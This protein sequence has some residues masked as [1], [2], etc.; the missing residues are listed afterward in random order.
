MSAHCEEEHKVE[1]EVP[2]VEETAEASEEAEEE[3]EQKPEIKVETAPQD[4]RFPSC[5]QSR[6]CFTRYNEFHKCAAEKGEDAEDCKF[7][8]RAYRSLCPGDWVSKWNEER[9]A[10]TFA[11]R[12]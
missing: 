5:N 11:G 12:Y 8:Q 1:E 9:E 7:Y 4:V 10:G 2:A 3:E 6:H